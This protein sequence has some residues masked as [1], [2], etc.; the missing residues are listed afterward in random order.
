LLRIEHLA[1]RFDPPTLALL[2]RVM[3]IG[4]DPPPAP[5]DDRI[6]LPVAGLEAS[7][8]LSPPVAD[9]WGRCA[10]AMSADLGR[11]ALV[12]S[13]YRSPAFQAMLIIWLAAN[14]NGDFHAAL[15]RAHPP[16][17]SEH[18]LPTDHAIDLTTAGAAPAEEP[19]HFAGTPECGWMRERGGEF[20]FVES[21]PADTTEPVGPEP[22]H[23]RGPLR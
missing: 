20:G 9:A 19:G 21:Y 12:S 15:L 23:W 8:W 18:C 10:D 4:G 1:G 7:A 3:H 11:P 22:W 14:R 6:E 2:E 13:G 5:I 17:R 16:S